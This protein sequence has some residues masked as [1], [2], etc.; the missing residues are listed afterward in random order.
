MMP[1]IKR[2]AS[3]SFSGPSQSLV[4]RKKSGSELNENGALT[5]TVRGN[6]QDGALVQS[7]SHSLMSHLRSVSG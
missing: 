7:V 4:K 6:A 1:A 5:T 2:Q 3:D